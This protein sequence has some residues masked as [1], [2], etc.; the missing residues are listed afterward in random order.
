MNISLGRYRVTGD[1]LV[2]RLFFARTT[3]VDGQPWSHSVVEDV[4]F[5]IASHEHDGTAKLDLECL[6]SVCRVCGSIKMCADR[7]QRDAFVAHFE[8]GC[9]KNKLGEEWLVTFTTNEA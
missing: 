8:V 7:E 2:N 6:V 1:Q 9:C 4:A 5:I 3:P